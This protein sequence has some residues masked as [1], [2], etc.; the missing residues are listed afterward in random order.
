MKDKKNV[1]I[2]FGGV[3]SEHKIS[4]ISAASV[5]RN[6]DTEKYNVLKMGI[7][8]EGDMFLTYAEPDSIEDG[9]W[10]NDSR[11]LFAMISPQRSTHGICIVEDDKM[12]TQ[13]IDVAFPVLHGKNGE[14]GT[15]QGL[16]EIAGIPYVGPGVEASAC[17]MDKSF[18]KLIVSATGVRQ[19]EAFVTDRY[20]FSENPNGIL[21]E[22]EKKFNKEYPLFVKPS[23]AGSSV[24][25]SR[26]TCFSELFDA[27][28]TALNEDHKV[29]IE[30]AVKGREIEVA[31]LGNRNVRASCLGE[32]IADGG[33]YDYESK[34]ENDTTETRIVDDLPEEKV[35]EFQESAIKVY[36]ALGC[37]GI[38]RVDFFLRED[39]EIVF[40]EINTLPGF[41]SI[42][43]Y[44]KLWQASGIAYGDL[45]DEI[46][47]LAMDEM[48]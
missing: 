28:T 29:L 47:M 19:A 23:S 15:I 7:T 36:R 40:N 41:T 48:E 26:V 2:V 45:I 11:N 21:A 37:K 14:D 1:L 42:S 39:N 35:K 16:F 5:I 17:S 34:Y 22:I 38:S 8:M 24:G 10:E 44:P 3:S 25:V 9:S 30:E 12:R 43:M 18:A 20:E 32:I 46:L 31:V 27:L 33:F 6:L 13:H 4:Q